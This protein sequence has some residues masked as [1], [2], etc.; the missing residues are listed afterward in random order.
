MNNHGT[1]PIPRKPNCASLKY[2]V[3]IDDIRQVAQRRLPK[4]VFD[5]IDGGAEDEVTLRANRDVFGDIKLKPRVLTDVAS[6]NLSVNVCGTEMKV[7]IGFAPT[8]LPGIVHPKA[9]LLAVAAAG[10]I[11]TVFTVSSASTHSIEKIADVANSPLWFQLYLWRDRNVMGQ[12]IDRAQSSGYS[13]LCVTVDVPVNGGRERDVYNGMTLPPRISLRN[14]LDV[15][16]KPQWCAKQ[17]TAPRITL[18][19]LSN[20]DASPGKD[21]STLAAWA[22]QLLYPACDWNDFRWIRQKWRG[23]LLV[24]GIMNA[25]DASMA[26]KYGADG[27]IVSNH[28]GRQLDG[29]PSTMEVLPSVVDAIK[30]KAEVMV[31]GGIR[32]GT[33]VI[34]AQALGASACMIGRPYLFGLAAGGERGIERVFEILTSEVDRGLAILGTPSIR[35]LDRSN[36]CWDALHKFSST[37]G[38]SHV[39]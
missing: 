16:S 5:F 13:A 32:R 9:E 38:D 29:L 25:Q 8:G 39:Q 4:M 27:V 31:D 3:N 19:N 35:N 34:K 28:G 2:A 7:P 1:K 30:S 12:L 15:M 20:M 36:I 11:G 33:D 22:Q 17:L 26:V 21:V 14:A 24:K 10:R 23:P 18:S 37:T 6:R